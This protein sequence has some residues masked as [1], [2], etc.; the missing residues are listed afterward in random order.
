MVLFAKINSIQ[1]KPEKENHNIG[2][3]TKT[4]LEE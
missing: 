1:I 4:S 2:E 3:D